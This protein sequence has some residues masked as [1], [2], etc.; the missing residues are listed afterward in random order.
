LPGHAPRIVDGRG[1]EA[2]RN[3]HRVIHLPRW[4]RNN[5][6]VLHELAHTLTNFIDSNDSYEHGGIFVHVM[7]TLL[8]RFAGYKYQ[9]LADSA[10]AYGLQVTRI[11][12]ATRLKGF[13]N[14]EV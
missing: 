4:S 10:K 5:I 9:V 11:Q 3:W 2:A 6:I 12:L 1:S 14:H 7:I 13:D 8:T